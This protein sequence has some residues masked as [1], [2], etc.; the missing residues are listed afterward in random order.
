MKGIFYNPVILGPSPSM[1]VSGNTV[2]SLVIPACA[3]M[4]KENEGDKR[5][6][7]YNDKKQIN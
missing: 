7:V 5:E 2:L 6:N 1:T 3:G 4:T